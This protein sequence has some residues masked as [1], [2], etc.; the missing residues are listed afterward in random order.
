MAYETAAARS[1]L[2]RAGRALNRC[3]DVLQLICDH[4]A[5]A[6]PEKPLRAG[7][8]ALKDLARETLRGLVR[9][10]QCARCEGLLGAYDLISKDYIDLL[11]ERNF[12]SGRRRTTVVE[13]LDELLAVSNEL[14]D[15]L[16]KE[17]RDHGEVH[18]AV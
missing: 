18:R 10:A 4:V 5:L 7:F 6:H 9:A 16:R 13:R 11:R 3:E 14:L 17:I 8:R 1:T 2:S 12:A 15:R